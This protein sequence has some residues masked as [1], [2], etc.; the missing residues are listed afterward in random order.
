[1]QLHDAH[2]HYHFAGLAPFVEAALGE[3]RRD[4]LAA[5]VVNGTGEEDW[6][7]VRDF[8]HNHRWTHAAYGIHPWQA[9]H[10]TSDWEETLRGYLEA[11]PSAS[12]GEIGLDAW[13]EEHDLADQTAL[14]LRQWALASE[15][16][17]P[18]TVHC[19]QAWE[20]LRQTLRRA[21]ALAS[22]FLIHAYNGPPQ[23]IPEFVDVGA[24]FSFSPYFLYERKR[25]QR[26]AFRLMP[27]DRILIETDAPAL[28]PP[29]EHNLHPLTDPA[30][31]EPLNHPANL[32]VA[33]HALAETLGCDTA[34]AAAPTTANWIRLFVGTSA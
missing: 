14:F 23:W 11:D 25:P 4:G 22:G 15:L 20:P 16:V 6:P 34:A 27:P 31:G 9:P 29:S 26:E 10:R 8:V 17:R 19:I 28:S 32:K 5:A 21:P 12:V 30:T 13:V 3:A 2:T 7:Q 33:L 1:M 24:Y 18:A